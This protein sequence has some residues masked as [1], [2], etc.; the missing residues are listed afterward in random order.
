MSPQATATFLLLVLSFATALAGDPAST[1]V[2]T[3]VVEGCKTDE[4]T[5]E[6]ALVDSEESYRGARARATRSATVGVSKGRAEWRFEGLPFG[7]YA[8]QVFHDENGNGRL[9]SNFLGIPKEPYGFSNNARGR[10]GPP[11]YDRIKF[12][13]RAGRQEVVIRVR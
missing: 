5:V 1:G 3:V 13:F 11:R 6:I 4:G 9:D 2:L 12:E 8:I 7:E 10:L